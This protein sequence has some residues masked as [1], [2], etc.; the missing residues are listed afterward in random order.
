MAVRPGEM[1]LLTTRVGA[2]LG[3]QVESNW[4]HPALYVLISLLRPLSAS[5]ILV[6]IY[7][8]VVGGD[9]STPLFAYLFIG[10]S[11]FLL[12]G[13][14]LFGVSYA[15]FLDRDMYEMF[16]YIYLTP[17]GM[18]AYLLGRS[19]TR[20]AT[21]L[22]AVGINLA[23]GVLVFDIPIPFGEIRWAAFLLTLGLGV[24]VSIFIGIFLAGI[25]LVTARHA[26]FL[27]EGLAGIF[28]L[29][30]GVIYTLEV[31]PGWGQSIARALPFTY[32]FASLRRSLG[33]AELSASLAD[34]PLGGML[35]TLALM[36]VGIG[37]AAH[38]FYSA[39]EWVGRRT[40]RID[41]VFNY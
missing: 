23:F 6:F 8:V 34:L 33:M 3:W 7:L 38:L 31:L 14:I 36:T 17:G 21:A 40:G 19:A 13:S 10:Q 30:C 41:M 16:K 1:R 24:T 22:V 29:L 25:H 26:W 12:V 27:G 15:I 5:F 2:W 4:T 39:M 18:Y 28:Y 35:S 32:W 11:F 37:V 9:T 20:I